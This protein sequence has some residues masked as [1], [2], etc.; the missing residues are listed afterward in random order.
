LIPLQSP[1]AKSFKPCNIDH[2]LDP[3]SPTLLS[4]AKYFEPWDIHQGGFISTADIEDNDERMK[5]F[6]PCNIDCRLDPKPGAIV[7]AKSFKPRD[8]NQGGADCR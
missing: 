8:I 3:L 5:S 4:Q 2:G 1:Q 7:V 6:K